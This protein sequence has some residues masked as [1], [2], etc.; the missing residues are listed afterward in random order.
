MT[1]HA[2]KLLTV[3]NRQILY[4][5]FRFGDYI[6]VDL[7]QYTPEYTRTKVKRSNVKVTP[8]LKTSRKISHVVLA[9]RSYIF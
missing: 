3:C 9:I 4:M 2:L 7:A 6:Y 1:P 5:N 8:K